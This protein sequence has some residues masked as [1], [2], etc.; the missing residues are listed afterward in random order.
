MHETRSKFCLFSECCTSQCL[1][2]F[3]ALFLEPRTKAFTVAD[4][5]YRWHT[6]AA[7]VSAVPA[8]LEVANEGRG[9]SICCI[10]VLYTNY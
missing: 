1:S 8:R 4:V 5:V 9:M 3:A 6:F 7:H 2:Q 10:A